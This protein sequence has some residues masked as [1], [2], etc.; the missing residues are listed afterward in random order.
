MRPDVTTTALR[1]LVTQL[2]KLETGNRFFGELVSGV[3][4][5]YDLGNDEPLVGRTGKN[6]RPR[7]IKIEVAG[8][9]GLPAGVMVSAPRISMSRIVLRGHVSSR[10]YLCCGGGRSPGSSATASRYGGGPR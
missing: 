1:N 3:S 2:M 9:G 6:M 7:G 4:A 10:I 5:R 8:W